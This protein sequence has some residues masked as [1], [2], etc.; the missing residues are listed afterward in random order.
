MS[1]GYVSMTCTSYAISSAFRTFSASTQRRLT[2]LSLLLV[3]ILQLS[4]VKYCVMTNIPFDKEE[5]S[6]WRPHKKE[7]SNRFR[8][9]LRVDPLLKGR[10]I[11]IG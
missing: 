4:G 11:L 2:F 5:A 10:H 6:H 1:S 8:S 9:A 7:Y 3:L